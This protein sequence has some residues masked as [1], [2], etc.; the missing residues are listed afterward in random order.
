[1]SVLEISPLLSVPGVRL[2]G[3]LD[4]ATV[5]LFTEALLELAAEREIY[6]DLATLTFLDSSGLHAILDVARSEDGDRSVI[7]VNPTA[8]IRRSLEIAG[9]AEHPRVEIR[10]AEAVKAVA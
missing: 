8:A 2:D 7:L 10:H 9:V 5:P 6:L 3:E 1:V 4:L